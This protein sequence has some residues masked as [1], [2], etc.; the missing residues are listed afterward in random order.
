MKSLIKEYTLT[1]ISKLSLE[2]TAE[3]LT[4]CFRA[5]AAR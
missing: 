4:D 2:G 5:V 1:A 3:T